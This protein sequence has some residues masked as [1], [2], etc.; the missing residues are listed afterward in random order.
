[1]TAVAR[2]IEITYGSFL[3]NVANKRYIDGYIRLDTSQDEAQLEFDF[4]IVQATEADFVGEVAA[5]ETAFSTPRKDLVITQGSET[6]LSLSHTA[7][8]GFNAEPKIIKA[9]DIADT[10]RSRRYTV[11]ITFGLPADARFV[12]SGRRDSTVEVFFKPSRRRRVSISG[13]YTALSGNDAKAQYDAAI[14]AYVS[15]VTAFLGGNFAPVPEE[16]RYQYDDQIK[17][18]N[19]TQV[20][21][22]IIFEESL[23]ALDDP[24]I[25]KQSLR[26]ARNKVRPGDCLQRIVPGSGAS[27]TVDRFIEMQVT[28]EAWIDHTVTTDLTGKYDSTIRPFLLQQAFKVG[29]R[30]DIGAL[31]QERPEFDLPDNRILCTMVVLVPGGPI[32]EKTCTTEL[33]DDF[34]KVLVAVWADDPSG[35]TYYEYQGPRKFLQTL[36]ETKRVLGRVQG[37]QGGGGRGGG[38]GGALFGFGAGF[39]G[40]LRQQNLGGFGILGRNFRPGVVLNFPAG[41]GGGGGAGRIEA[42]GDVGQGEIPQGTEPVLIDRRFTTQPLNLGSEDHRLDVT[43]VTVTEQR[44]F[45]RRLTA[46][47]GGGRQTRAL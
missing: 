42:G 45:I 1:M 27:G 20:F 36:T 43:D 13:I 37:V 22:E 5:V 10:G 8:T 46:G 18:L 9:E 11:R 7:N 28:Y 35:L 23:S 25:T 21:E 41:A 12:T 33:G 44:Q 14:V 32:L 24:A 29:G 19:F 4:V 34:G 38:A 15:L 31:T 17:V 3:V 30:G 2:E 39:R 40:G 26:I 16:E 47:G 6:L